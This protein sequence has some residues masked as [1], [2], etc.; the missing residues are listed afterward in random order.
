M[1]CAK[2]VWNLQKDEDGLYYKLCICGNKIKYSTRDG[3]KYSIKN[4][5]VCKDCK[6]TKKE[7]KI[8]VRMCPECSVE[9]K[10][11]NIFYFRKAEKNKSKCLSCSNKGRI[12][13]D[14]GRK[15][16]SKCHANVFG[17]NNPF[18]GKT[19]TDET[20]SKIS[21]SI[22]DEERSKRRIRCLERIRSTKRTA[23][24]NKFACKYFDELNKIKGWNLIHA[25][26]GG[27]FIVDGYSL[28]AYDKEKNIVVEYDES[29]HYSNGMLR[30]KDILRQNKIIKVLKCRF[31]RYNENADNL[32]EV[33]EKSN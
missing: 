18:F 8:Y 9:L 12:I 27:E 23:N 20:K 7:S 30:E 28:D 3:V 32:Y 19:H 22:S 11:K 31:F 13:S 16:M 15:N 1:S 25:L 10:T 14:E 26:N 29:K 5:M 24:F 6:K 17:K 2:S 21:Q 33:Y 4:N